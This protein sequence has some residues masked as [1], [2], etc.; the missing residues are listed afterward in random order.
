MISMKAILFSS[1]TVLTGNVRKKEFRQ[2]NK[3]V[4]KV[5]KEQVYW[6]IWKT[7]LCKSPNQQM[8]LVSLSYPDNSVNRVPE[9]RCEIVKLNECLDSISFI[10]VL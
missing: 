3:Y 9:S 2:K 6:V 4:V 5:N 10:H 7:L 1:G 8:F